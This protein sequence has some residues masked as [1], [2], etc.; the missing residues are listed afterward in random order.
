M[1]I[2]VVRV[3]LLTQNLSVVACCGAVCARLL[4]GEFQWRHLLEAC[5]IILAIV[6]QLASVAY[7][8][9]IE[10]DWIV[11]VAAGNESLLASMTA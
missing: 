11:V 5:V 1:C 2:T 8:I 9:A 3:S 4:Y 6:A 7:K 10:K